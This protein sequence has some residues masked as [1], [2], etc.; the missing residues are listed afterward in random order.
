MS[1]KLPKIKI[2]IVHAHPGDI[3]CEGAGTVAI[4]T[5]RGDDVYCL[6]LSDG[7]RHHN[8]LIHRENA[9]PEAERNLKIVNSTVKEIKAYKRAEAQRI[10]DFLGMKKMYALGWPDVQMECT[11]ENISQIADVIRQVRPD[12]LLTSMP[13]G[14]R[15]SQATDVHA[16]TGHMTRLAARYCSDSLPQIDGHEPHHTKCIFYY[17]MMGMAD[18]TS[19]SS[20]GVVCD[21]WV[22][23]T[24]VIDKKVQVIDLLVSQGYQGSCSRK[25]V[26]AREGRW[27]M[28]CGSSYAEPWMRERAIR[29][30]RLPV[31]PED[32]GKKYC[33]NDL[34][35]DQVLCK[36]VPV[37]IPPESFDFPGPLIAEV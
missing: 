17:P 7:E 9:K 37:E 19:M 23:I 11:H 1:E 33:P 21:V 35:G 10:C 2:L 18:T 4:H 27:G 12:V 26:E 14:E 34:P 16:A 25:L 22:D 36:D 20:S 15:A 28:L 32:L 8:D 6:V 24:P 13:W 5:Q 29:Y 31:R 30:T 3:C